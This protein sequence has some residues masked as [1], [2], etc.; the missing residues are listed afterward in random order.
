MNVIWQGNIAAQRGGLFG[1][2]PLRKTHERFVDRIL[3]EQWLSSIRAHG[4]E[5]NGTT[6][7]Y[8]VETGRNLGIL[9][10]WREASIMTDGSSRSKAALALRKA[11]RLQKKRNVRAGV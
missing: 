6:G 5:E 7:K 3:R 11:K 9:V 8:V 1:V 10:H 2:S 4:N